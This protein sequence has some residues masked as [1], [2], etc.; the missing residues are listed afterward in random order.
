MEILLV[1]PPG[2]T[3]RVGGSESPQTT[4]CAPLHSSHRSSLFQGVIWMLRMGLTGQA[5]RCAAS[6]LG[7]H[8]AV[9]HIVRGYHITIHF[10]VGQ[11]VRVVWMV[12]YNTE[13]WWEGTPTVCDCVRRP[14]FQSERESLFNCW[15][16][17]SYFIIREGRGGGLKGQKAHEHRVQMVIVMNVGCCS[18]LSFHFALCSKSLTVIM[19]RFL[20]VK[21]LWHDRQVTKHCHWLAHLDVWER[22]RFVLIFI[23]CRRRSCRCFCL[24]CLFRENLA[25]CSRHERSEVDGLF[26]Q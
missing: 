10:I 11:W 9:L 21:I 12:E 1:L 3:Q 26:E 19:W 4:H 20:C 13:A 23:L 7:I 24:G 25:V 6:M 18:R 8:A 22:W 16:F 17:H 14:V 5:A 2:W 15:W